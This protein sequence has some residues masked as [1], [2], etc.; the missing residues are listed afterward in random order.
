MANVAKLH[1]YYVTNAQNELNY[2]GQDITDENF[3]QFMQDYAASIDS[4]EDMFDLDDEYGEDED[5]V[6][7]T[8]IDENVLEIDTVLNL[9]I[10][11][12]DNSNSNVIESELEDHGNPDFDIDDILNASSSL[13]TEN[14]RVGD[15]NIEE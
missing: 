14:S 3:E 6:D 7:L 4:E 11:M 5:V 13:A 15:D 1:S 10:L 2:I 8:N 9:G 12:T